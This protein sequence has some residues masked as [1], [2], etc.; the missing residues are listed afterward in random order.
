MELI[1]LGLFAMALSYLIGA[2]PF[3]FLIVKLMYRQDIRQLGSGN[4]GATNVWRC[5]GKWPGISTLLLDLLKGIIPVLA[6]NKIFPQ[7]E[8]LPI[9]C[10]LAAITGHNWNIFLR[11]KGGKGVATSAGVF[12]ALMPREFGIALIVFLAVLL[13]SRRVSISSICGAVALVTSVCL[14]PERYYFRL[15]A[16]VA[17]LM[18]LLKHIPNFR[19]L[20]KGE[21][22]KVKIS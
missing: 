10:G 15:L 16:I 19:R 11:G 22:P 21:E 12:L 4:P 14:F 13:I 5:F 18:I 8:I 7:Y 2:I 17:S 3:G 6:V 20:L 9:F 1:A